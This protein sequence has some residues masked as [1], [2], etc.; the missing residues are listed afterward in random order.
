M[1]KAKIIVVAQQKGGAGK[2]TIA[3]H[4]A[5]ALSQMNNKVAVIDIDPQGSL[6]AWYEIRKKKFGEDYTGLN[7]SATSGWRIASIISKLKDNFEYI[8]I[9]SPPH[10]E[11]DS[12]S[13]IREA[14]LLVV[15]LQP[16]PADLWAS[17]STFKFAEQE[18][19]KFVA[20][21]NRVSNNS[22]LA[23]ELKKEIPNLAKAR[24]GNRT[25]FAGAFLEGKTVTETQ[26]K[27][28]AAEEVK[29][30]VKEIVNTMS[31]KEKKK[32]A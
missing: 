7:F 14:T 20:V 4:V 24:L 27:S 16:S 15:P 25:A 21:M 22:K 8:V 30:L 13:A 9:D 32:A 31:P 19:I 12:K 18:K 6:T 2:T 26:P 3:A 29:A 28:T 23:E 10:T 17:K 1:S 5:V 11:T